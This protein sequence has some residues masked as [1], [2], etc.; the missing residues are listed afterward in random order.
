MLDDYRHANGELDWFRIGHLVF[1]IFYYTVIF[2]AVVL[3]IFSVFALDFHLNEF[4]KGV[5]Q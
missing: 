1:N 3:L 4:V 5:Q 2:A